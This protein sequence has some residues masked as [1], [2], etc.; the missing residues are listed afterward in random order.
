MPSVPLPR[1]GSIGLVDHEKAFC[2]DRTTGDVFDLRGSDHDER[3]VVVRPDQYVAHVLSLDEHQAVADFL[4][5]VLTDARQRRRLTR[6][7]GSSRSSR[8][9]SRTAETGRGEPVGSRR[10]NHYATSHW[11]AN[12]RWTSAR[13]RWW[14]WRRP[15][16]LPDQW[17][18]GGQSSF[19]GPGPGAA[20]G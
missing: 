7:H 4:S 18:R 1:K 19:S 10:I 20:V 12:R 8:A 15:G 3:C 11:S 5:G 14:S 17:S 2:P 16:W 13:S 6:S 9:S